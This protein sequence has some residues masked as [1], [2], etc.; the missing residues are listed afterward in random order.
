MSH[1]P[2][3]RS[4]VIVLILLL[5]LALVSYLVTAGS[6][7]I[8]EAMVALGI[9]VVKAALVLWWFMNLRAQGAHHLLAV[10]TAA[11][12]TAILVGLIVTDVALRPDNQLW[13]RHDM[14]AEA[15]AE[16][17]SADPDR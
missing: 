16:A 17:P 12:F 7:G 4:Q 11:A 10:L 3:P 6:P 13:Y 15:A 5:I 14:D 2:R 9:G 1:H 8:A